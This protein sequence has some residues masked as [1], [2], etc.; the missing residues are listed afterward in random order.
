MGLSC[1]GGSVND[2]RE[3]VDRQNRGDKLEHVKIS[4]K[5]F[6]FGRRFAGWGVVDGSDTLEDSARR[7]TWQIFTSK[8]RKE[9]SIIVL[10]VKEAWD[11]LKKYFERGTLANYNKLSSRKQYFF[12]EMKEGTTMQQHLKHERSGLS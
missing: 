6:T 4:N 12:S 9:F 8:L 7:R 2:R 3:V 5:L 1:P 11:A 10:A